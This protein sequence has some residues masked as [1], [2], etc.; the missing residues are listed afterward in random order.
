ME[1]EKCEL[2]PRC[3]FAECSC[4]DM[5]SLKQMGKGRKKKTSKNKGKAISKF[6][7]VDGVLKPVYK[8]DKNGI[9]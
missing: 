9:N 2:Y 7:I 4:Y 6:E 8:E 5:A 3:Q 1:Y